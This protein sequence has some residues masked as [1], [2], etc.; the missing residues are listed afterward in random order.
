MRQLGQKH[1]TST[2][3]MWRIER[4]NHFSVLLRVQCAY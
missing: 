4:D 2:G 3:R 1:L